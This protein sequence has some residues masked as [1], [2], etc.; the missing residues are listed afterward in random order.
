MRDLKKYRTGTF[1][2]RT[3]IISSFRKSTSS[4]YRFYKNTTPEYR[5]GNIINKCA[6]THKLS[7]L[8]IKH[9]DS[10]AHVRFLLKTHESVDMNFSKVQILMSVYQSTLKMNNLSHSST[11]A[12]SKPFWVC[13]A[14]FADGWI[15]NRILNP[16]QVLG[17]P[18]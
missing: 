7:H 6:C 11:H 10:F 2:S 4:E 1:F 13:A 17:S 16:Q 3:A 18:S 9:G 12:R 14:P 15:L 8:E 5:L